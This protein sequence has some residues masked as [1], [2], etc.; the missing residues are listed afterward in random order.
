VEA[1]LANGQEVRVLDNFSTGNLGNLAHVR[2]RITLL[3]GDLVDLPTV[4]SAVEHVELV[5][6]LGGVASVARSI[7]DPLATHQACAKGTLHVLLAAQEARVRRV[8]YAAS[9]SV[10]GEAVSLPQRE[11]VSLQPVSP[12]GVAKLTGEHYC[13]A[14]SHVYGMDTVRLRYF[15]VFGPRQLSGSPYAAVV[16][17][18]IQAMLAGRRPVIFGD[19]LQSRDFIDVD[20]IVQANLLAA[21]APRV[22]GRAYNI[23]SGRRTTALELVQCLNR[24][25]GTEMRPIHAPPRPG[26]VRHSQADITRAQADLGFCPCT[27]LERSL[28]RCVEYYAKHR[29]GPKYLRKQTMAGQLASGDK[30]PR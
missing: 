5:F 4:R 12:H 11:S 8:I 9:A 20:D 16:P 30:V 13:T 18:F 21:D 19:G 22:S 10:Y 14:F 3:Q 17:L 27:D 29:K 6:H 7:A 28:R 26:D 25:L 24:L 1:L 23:G 15:N 2:K